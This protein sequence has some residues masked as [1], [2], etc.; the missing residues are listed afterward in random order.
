MTFSQH[1][2]LLSSDELLT[3]ATAIQKETA[4]R[5]EF[6]DCLVDVKLTALSLTINTRDLLYRVMN[7]RLPGAA[8]KRN[9]D[10]T[11]RHLFALLKKEDWIHIE[12]LNSR[13]FL[14]IRDTLIRH[15]APLEEY[16]GTFVEKNTPV[17][18]RRLVPIV[19]LGI[20]K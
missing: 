11:I 9:A 2:R 3:I 15:N 1:I 20:T 10:L 6:I 18:N 17:L 13:A 8:T 5:S 7:S 19:D 12:Y 16:Y 4:R 14:E